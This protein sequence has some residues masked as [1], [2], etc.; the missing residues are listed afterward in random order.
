ML[1]LLQKY[2]K[3]D[4][5]DSKLFYLDILKKSYASPE[6]YIDIP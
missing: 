5:F 6:T 3:E 2:L 1:I 4:S